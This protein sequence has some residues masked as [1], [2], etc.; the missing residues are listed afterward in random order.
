MQAAA[1]SGD[2]REAA[3]STVEA[4]V[5]SKT[6]RELAISPVS[7]LAKVRSCVI[8]SVVSAIGRE[9]EAGGGQSGAI[10]TRL[11]AVSTK[12]PIGVTGPG[13]R[14]RISPLPVVSGAASLSPE[15][16]TIVLSTAPENGGSKG[17][18]SAPSVSEG[19][20]RE[21]FS[22]VVLTLPNLSNCGFSRS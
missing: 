5:M 15:A 16:S 22:K 8:G 21:S 19:T 11:S 6:M 9:T 13:G 1:A 2:M 20:I 18:K 10:A 4:D 17:G 7:T 14:A 3:W 12:A